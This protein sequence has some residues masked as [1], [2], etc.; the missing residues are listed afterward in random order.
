MVAALV[1]GVTGVGASTSTLSLHAGDSV[2]IQCDGSKGLGHTGTGSQWVV[3]CKGAPPV[4]TSAAPSSSTPVPTT[5][6]PTTTPPSSCALP[7]YPGASCTG[8][9]AGT[10]M[11]SV[12]GDLDVTAAGVIDAKNVSGCINVHVPGVTIMD[13]QASCINTLDTART[14]SPWLII[15]DTTVTCANISKPGS[16]DIGDNNIKV[17]R[18]NISGCENGFDADQNF[19]I[20]DSWIHDLYQSVQAHTDG[21]Q[22]AIGSNI[23]INHNRIEAE[24]PALCGAQQGKNCGGTSAINVNNNSAGPHTTN[25]IITNNWLAGGAYTL[26]CPIPAST[27]VQVVGNRFSRE[28]YPNGGNYGTDSDCRNDNGTPRIA[29]WSNNVW[30]DTGLPV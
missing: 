9:P 15:Q 21:L 8:V 7:N 23:T 13:S 1:A 6:A 19:D 3:N 18:A 25:L 27:N 4:T 28:F 11:T 14:A 30:D 2:T 20:E 16:T 17:Y 12:S 29:V 24:T 5:S 22:S 26:Y 10:A